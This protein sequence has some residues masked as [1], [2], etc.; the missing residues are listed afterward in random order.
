MGAD[1]FY[2]QSIRQIT[3]RHAK[4]ESSAAF[5]NIRSH[6]PNADPA[7]QMRPPEMFRELKQREPRV[8]ARWPFEFCEEL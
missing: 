4:V 7:V 1:E 6:L 2:T 3:D 5:E 8:V